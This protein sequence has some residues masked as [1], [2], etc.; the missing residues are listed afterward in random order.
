M[1]LQA[2]AKEAK[3]N[4]GEWSNRDNNND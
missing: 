1:Y 4:G 2:K 3:N